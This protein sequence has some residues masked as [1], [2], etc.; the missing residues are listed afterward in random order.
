MA[1]VGVQTSGGLLVV[2][3]TQTQQR[4][5]ERLGGGS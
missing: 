1:T 3:D 5:E 2:T 4:G